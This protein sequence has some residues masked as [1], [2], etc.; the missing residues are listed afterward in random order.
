[1]EGFSAH[2]ALTSSTLKTALAC[3]NR[4][5]IGRMLVELD[6]FFEEA[7]L[8]Y[9]QSLQISNGLSGYP[10]LLKNILS[11]VQQRQQVIEQRAK[12]LQQTVVLFPTFLANR[13]LARFK[14]SAVLA[15]WK[16]QSRLSTS[17][18]PC[19][20]KQSNSHRFDKRTI[21]ILTESFKASPTPSQKE[22]AMLRN[23]TKLTEK[24]ISMW[25]TNRRC[26]SKRAKTTLPVEPACRIQDSDCSRSEAG[27]WSPSVSLAT[28]PLA[29][30]EPQSIPQRMINFQYSSEDD[31]FINSRQEA[32]VEFYQT[33]FGQSGQYDWFGFGSY[34]FTGGR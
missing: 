8:F 9:T 11:T 33:M 14:F 25:F 29:A 22:L 30:T 2:V 26:R 32:E 6:N 23:T 1:M 15:L 31:F 4:G 12:T 34:S 5:D 20:E 3:L 19:V 24:Q 7:L 17:N 28:P 18:A 10:A 27:T 21:G 16:H 13:S